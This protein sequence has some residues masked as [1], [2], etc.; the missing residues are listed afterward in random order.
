[1]EKVLNI[2]DTKLKLD[3]IVSNVENAD[4]RQCKDKNVTEKRQ[5]TENP[6]INRIVAKVMS[7]PIHTEQEQIPKEKLPSLRK[8]ISLEA[9]KRE[10]ILMITRYKSSLRFSDYLQEEMKFSFEVKE[11]AKLSC[12]EL[13]TL[14]DDIRFCVA[15]K[16][17]QGLVNDG[18]INVISMVERLLTNLYKIDGLSKA[19]KRDDAFLDILEEW[20]L[21]NQKLTRTSAK[22]RL[23]FE[24]VKTA[25]MIHEMHNHIEKI[26][27]TKEGQEELKKIGEEIKKVEAMQQQA[28]KVEPLSVEKKEI[29]KEFE[30]KYKSLF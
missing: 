2:N 23:M 13:R 21:E 10:L 9:E 4:K 22:T 6:V 30:E 26:A 19:L 3:S 5:V 11:L 16:N 28:I 20:T 29:G 15:N 7:E 8:V 12:N 17:N 1:M 14:L 27:S 25:Y 18:V 24:I